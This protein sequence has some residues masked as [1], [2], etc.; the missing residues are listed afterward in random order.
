MG[1]AKE[2]TP[3]SENMTTSFE[4]FLSEVRKHAPPLKEASLFS[5]GGRGYYENPASDLLAFFMAPDA[6]HGFKDLFLQAFLECMKVDSASLGMAGVT[7]SR[8]AVTKEGNRIDLVVNGSDWVLLIE[9]KVHHDQVNPFASY[10]AYGRSLLPGKMLLMAI[11]SPKG[12]SVHGS[13]QPVSYQTYCSALRRRLADDMFNRAY[14]KWLIFAREFIL[15]FE[16]EL[17]QPA[18]NDEQANFVELHGEQIEL[19][20]KLSSEYRLFLLALLKS[21]LEAAILGRLFT[22]KD[23]VWAVRCSE[24]YWGRSNLA[25]WSATSDGALKF[26][27]AVYLIEITPEQE[28]H[29]GRVFRD[30]HRLTAWR[31]G[32]WFAWRTH[33]GFNTR[34]EAI[35]ELC[36]LGCIL[37]ELFP[38]PEPP[39]PQAEG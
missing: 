20:K 6:V 29:A 30:A 38:K 18:M 11:L 24:Q 31:E 17:Y 3:R 39:L 32:K 33:P 36:S 12:E 14:S 21:R 13:W 7:V 23:D 25:F 34:A 9:N 26:Y 2:S 37:A 16:N 15:H 1:N 4:K 19:A 5:L 22:T 35:A 10:E 28:D 27:V 8:E